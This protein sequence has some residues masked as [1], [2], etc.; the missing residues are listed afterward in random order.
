MERM[1]TK[2]DISIELPPL[3]LNSLNSTPSTSH[4]EDPQPSLSLQLP[5]QID[6]GIWAILAKKTRKNSSQICQ[7]L[8]IR[9][10]RRNQ[11]ILAIF[12]LLEI[13]DDKLPENSREER[14]QLAKGLLRITQY[15]VDS[16]AEFCLP[17][18]A[19][20][21]LD[22]T[23][24]II[25]SLQEQLN[26]RSRRII[27]ASTAGIF[28]VGR[29]MVV[30]GSLLKSLTDI[31]DPHPYLTVPTS[32]ILASF[33][34]L[35]S[36]NMLKNQSLKQAQDDLFAKNLE[37]PPASK[38]TLILANLMAIF[39]S[40]TFASLCLFLI[41]RLAETFSYSLGTAK[42]VNPICGAEDFSNFFEISAIILAIFSLAAVQRT[43]QDDAKKF[44]KD[45]PSELAS[46]WP[47]KETIIP[48]LA[49]N[50]GSFILKAGFSYCGAS[51]LLSISDSTKRCYAETFDG[52]VGAKIIT[53][54]S[55]IC[56]TPTIWKSANKMSESFIGLIKKCTNYQ[57]LEEKNY[58]FYIQEQGII[59]SRNIE[60]LAI[61]VNAIAGLA[62][63]INE[64]IS[65]QEYHPKDS[66]DWVWIA[67]SLFFNAAVSYYV[68]SRNRVAISKAQIQDEERIKKILQGDLAVI[69]E[70]YPN[71]ELYDN[72]ISLF[73]VGKI[74][75]ERNNNISSTSSDIE[76][77]IGD[78]DNPPSPPA[79]SLAI[80]TSSIPQSSVIR[81]VGNAMENTMRN[82]MGNTMR[83]DTILNSSN[84][85]LP[86]IFNPKRQDLRNQ[87]NQLPPASP[88]SG[89]S[90]PPS[91]LNT[92]PPQLSSTFSTPEAE[93]IETRPLIKP[94]NLRLPKSTS[95]PNINN[96]GP[97]IMPL[98]YKECYSDPISA[99]SSH[100]K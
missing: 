44:F 58:S 41:P 21:L 91:F 31:F 37:S 4:I 90:N 70:I 23:K 40:L 39:Y 69:K 42:K 94:N 3:S 36:Y 81:N 14:S 6:T 33:C 16:Y 73:E 38:K 100:Y 89:F 29:G 47:F 32:F 97:I 51:R 93:L 95:T 68:F 10:K 74:F 49:K 60:Q 83:N 43:S 87:L 30:F 71:L 80:L 26:R 11:Q 54:L 62:P 77:N 76:S 85:T 86:N 34:I 7:E 22:S 24:Q 66:K 8:D 99:T 2:H 57:E 48:Q 13:I 55:L 59:N 5:G 18:E 12:A 88:S 20:E 61:A 79:P 96:A 28:G 78:D 1:K 15:S 92:S 82:A 45:M 19:Q 25:L 75:V 27:R 35:A 56:S 50:W 67:Q 72:K 17:K 53:Y 9:V 52:Y 46:L 98:A 84:L 64:Y 65:N 63:T